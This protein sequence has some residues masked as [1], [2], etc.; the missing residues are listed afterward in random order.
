MKAKSVD[1]GII[2]EVPL[3]QWISII[4]SDGK[5]YGMH[6]SSL[7]FLDPPE[8]PANKLIDLEEKIAKLKGDFER[9]IVELTNRNEKLKKRV[10]DLEE[11]C[12]AGDLYKVKALD[13]NYSDLSCGFNELTKKVEKLEL[14]NKA[15]KN[16]F[17]NLGIPVHPACVQKFSY[18]EEEIEK[19]IDTALISINMFGVPRLKSSILSVLRKNKEDK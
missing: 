13:I 19:A 15:F 16:A 3:D 17:A 18:T 12:K 8:E 7:I 6:L 4:H 11:L 9:A 10:I 1:T 14:D 2:Y 5:Q